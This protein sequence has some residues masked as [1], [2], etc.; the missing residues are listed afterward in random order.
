MTTTSTERRVKGG[1]G[2]SIRR[3]DGVPKLTG[4]CAYASAPFHDRMLWGA[5][6]RSPYAKA[7]IVRLDVTPALAMAGVLA[8]LTQV[9][10]PG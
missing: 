2:K 4:N 1:V 6:L 9:D 8:V 5:T 3:A 10:V 7:R